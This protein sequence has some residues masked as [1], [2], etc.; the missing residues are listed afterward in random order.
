[1]DFITTPLV[2]AI[3]FVTIYKLFK[4]LVC[5]KERILYIEYLIQTGR[6]LVP[7]PIDNMP[8]I[9][10][11]TG[12]SLDFGA[13]FNFSALKWGC[14]LCG[15][16]LGLLVGTL[17]VCMIFPHKDLIFNWQVNSGMPGL[18]IGSS[19]ML[20]GGL[21]LVLAYLIDGRTRRKQETAD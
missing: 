3:I 10:P 6:G 21:G 17:L 1:M 19:A 18:I 2:V 12:E 9:Q 20:F 4:L 5:R 7:P 14:L 8:V 16:G 11:R 15:L 13:L